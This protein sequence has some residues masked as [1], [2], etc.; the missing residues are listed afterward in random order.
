MTISSVC[1]RCCLVRRPGSL[2]LLVPS[3][4]DVLCN[5][6]LQYHV[7]LLCTEFV[8]D[9][10]GCGDLQP[11]ALLKGEAE[12]EKLTGRSCSSCNKNPG[13]L[14]KEACTLVCGGGDG[15]AFPFLDLP[16]PVLSFSV[17]VANCTHEHVEKLIH[18]TLRKSVSRCI[19]S[20]GQ[21]MISRSIRPSRRRDAVAYCVGFP[22]IFLPPSRRTLPNPADK[23]PNRHLG[24][25]SQTGALPTAVL[26]VR[27]ILPPLAPTPLGISAH[28]ITQSITHSTIAASRPSRICARMEIQ[29][30]CWP[31]TYCI[32]EHVPNL[33][34]PDASAPETSA[35][36][37]PSN[38]PT[39]GHG[40]IHEAACV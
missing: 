18:N 11:R 30:N 33:R 12:L 34:L 24:A 29:R 6:F 4:A 2:T 17:L 13:N 22:V 1:N 5:E 40:D 32:I 14:G 25:T 10:L 36:R 21:S 7:P 15:D 27:H 9:R 38:Q 31:H 28:A 3:I 26:C 8:G 16:C 19:R 37:M 39:S 35:S 20:V 23:P